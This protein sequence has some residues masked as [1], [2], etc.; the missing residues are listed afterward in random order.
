MSEAAHMQS[1][2]GADN[3][4]GPGARRAQVD[5]FGSALVRIYESGADHSMKV[6]LLDQVVSIIRRKERPDERLQ[7]IADLMRNWE[8]H[9]RGG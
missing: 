8:C 2:R 3:S 1:K 4:T 9:G 5:G 7:D 6:E